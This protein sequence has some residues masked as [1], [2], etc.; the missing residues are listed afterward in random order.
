MHSPNDRRSTWVFVFAG[1]QGLLL[2]FSRGRGHLARRGRVE[3]Q[4]MIA[5]WQVCRAPIPVF[6]VAFL[7]IL[8]TQ[9]SAHALFINQQTSAHLRSSTPTLCAFVSMLASIVQQALHAATEG[10]LT[11]RMHQKLA[12]SWVTA[13]Q[14]WLSGTAWACHGTVAAVSGRWT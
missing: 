12:V 6:V 8:V 14:S 3:Y 2:G 10:I 4:V 9:N 7:S 5:R 13:S 1:F 11:M